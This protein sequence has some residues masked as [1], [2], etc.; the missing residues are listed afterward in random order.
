MKVFLLHRDQDFAVKPELRDAIFDA[1][2]SGDLFAI[3][4]ARRDRE[5]QREPSPP[6][7]PTGNDAVLTQDLELRTLWDAMAAG[8]QFLFEMAKR[9]VLSGLT[10]P[11]AIIGSAPASSPTTNAKRTPRCKAASSTRNLPG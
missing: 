9:A 6:L 7:A 3:A 8:D 4:N 2:M 11:D 10:D 5:R 1:M